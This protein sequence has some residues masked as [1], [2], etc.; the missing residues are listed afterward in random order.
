M[1]CA[2]DTLLYPIVTD[3]VACL[4]QEYALADETLCFCGVE[5][6]TGVPINVGECEG[7]ACGAA[8][9]RL[10]R[11]FPSSDFPNV[12]NTA[13][14]ATM[15]AMEVV[16]TVLRCVPT[17]QDDGSNPTAEEYAFWAQQQYADMIAMRRSITCCFTSA[18]EDVEHVLLEYTPLT[19]QGGVGGGQWR[20]LVRQEF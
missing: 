14:C 7:G 18:H 10:V 15:L 13:T 6:A 9:V 1:A 8:T 5:P 2:D 20:L 4:C 19:P 16:V 11:V 17:G 12:D 3:L